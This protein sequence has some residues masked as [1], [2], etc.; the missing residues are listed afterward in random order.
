MHS[1]MFNDQVTM[2]TLPDTEEG[3]MG[4]T[5]DWSTADSR[6]A[7]ACIL[8]QPL[9]IIDYGQNESQKKLVKI[10]LRGRFEIDVANTRFLWKTST[11]F[12]PISSSYLVSR[13]DTDFT[14]LL[15]HQIDR[16]T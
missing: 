16:L 12:Q 15:C 4:L 10:I 5:R 9:K 3:P 8:E 6:L 11:V 2:L 1:S 13:T 14:I 7:W